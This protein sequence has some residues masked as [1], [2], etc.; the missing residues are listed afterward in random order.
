MTKHFA[1]ALAVQAL[2]AAAVPLMT[3]KGLDADAAF[4]VRVPAGG[5]A[6]VRNSPPGEPEID[7]SPPAYRYER[8]IL[9][10]IAAADHAAL[11]AALVAI[12]A[13]I[14]ADR[15]L[16]G[17]CEWL[18]AIAPGIDD[19][20]AEGTKTLATATLAVVAAYSTDNPLL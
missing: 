10:E 4:P 17:L 19:F 15:H 20:A 13:A 3:V 11:D 16:G 2:I 12:G 18:D 7:L 9:V 8:Q 5:L 14:V 1:V 6:I